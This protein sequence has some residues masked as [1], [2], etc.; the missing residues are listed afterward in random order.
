MEIDGFATFPLKPHPLPRRPTL[1]NP[2]T[3]RN[4][5]LNLNEFLAKKLPVVGQLRVLGG[6]AVVL[7]ELA[8]AVSGGLVELGE[9]ERALYRSVF[10]IEF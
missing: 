3:L 7:A 9:P 10:G 5:E 4:F 6:Q 2:N 1:N 8:D